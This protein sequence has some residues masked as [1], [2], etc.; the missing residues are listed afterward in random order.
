[1]IS[2]ASEILASSQKGSKTSGSLTEGD[3]LARVDTGL[4]SFTNAMQRLAEAAAQNKGTVDL[5]LSLAPQ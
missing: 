3:V 2:K 4:T 1:M 5:K